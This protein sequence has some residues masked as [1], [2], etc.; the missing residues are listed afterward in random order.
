MVVENINFPNGRTARMVRVSAET[1]PGV[2]LSSLGVKSPHALVI[3]SGGADKMNPERMASVSPLLENGLVPLVVRGRMAILDGGTN[4]GVMALVGEAVARYGVTVPLIGVC[5]A[6][7]VSWPSHHNPHAEAELE[8][9]HTHF[10]L[11]V[12]GHEFGEESEYLYA[13]AEF[14]GRDVPSIALVI[15]GGRVTLQETWWNA[16]QGREIVVLK[17]SGRA[18]DRIA[19]AWEAGEADDPL[20]ADILR[21]ERITLFDIKKG[22]EALGNLIQE[23]LWRV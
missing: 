9:Y 22:P 15:N 3:L 12:P 1:P 18:A 7:K 13:I 8:P 21:G 5:P 17:G 11:V 20:I 4:S 10:V 19:Q 6:G 16:M 14:L 2:V 23:R